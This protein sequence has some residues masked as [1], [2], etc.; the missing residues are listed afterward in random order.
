MLHP[1]RRGNKDTELWSSR[2]TDRRAATMIEY[3]NKI[4]LGT[5]LHGLFQAAVVAVAL[6]SGFLT[7]RDRIHDVEVDLAQEK[8]TVIVLQ[9]R[10]ENLQLNMT[11]GLNKLQDLLTALQVEDAK[12]SQ[13]GRK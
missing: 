9:G 13:G 1:D 11:S 5:I 3:D 7:S 8:Q 6:A 4:S 2:D 12:R 10:I